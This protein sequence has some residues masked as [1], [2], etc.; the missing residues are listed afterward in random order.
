MLNYRQG[1]K[2]DRGREK[3]RK[4]DT[5]RDQ[6]VYIGVISLLVYRG[7]VLFYFST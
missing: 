5:Q 1:D 4:R 6:N 3:G 2:R 7:F